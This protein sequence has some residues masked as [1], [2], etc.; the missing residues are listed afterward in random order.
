MNR[1]SLVVVIAISC[2]LTAA[3][4]DSKPLVIRG[5]ESVGAPVTPQVLDVN[6]AELPTIVPWRAGDPITEVPRR[7]YPPEGA[8]RGAVNPLPD[9]LA[10]LQASTP[11]QSMRGFT[12]PILA[13]E[14]V[15]FTGVHPPDPIGDIGPNHYIHALNDS[16][17]A[18]FAI[19]D[20]AGTLLAGPSKMDEIPDAG[21]AC[22]SGA[23]DPI[24]LYDRD[25][26]RWFMQEFTQANDL[27]IYISQGPDPVNDGWYLYRYRQSLFPDYP[28]FGVWP[29]GYYT[30]TN[31][32]SS[33]G[34]PIYVFDR[35]NMITGSTARPQQRFTIPK[36]SGYG[37]QAATPADLDGDALPPAGAGGI[38]MRHVDDEAHSGSPDPSGDTLDL[39]TVTIDWDN[40]GNSV[41]AAQT[42]I[43]ITEY[44]SWFEDYSTFYSVPQPDATTELDPIRECILQRLQYRRFD[45][46]ESLVGVFPT[47]IDPATTGDSVNAGLRWFELRRS[48]GSG[49]WSL[50]QEGTFDVGEVSENRFEGSVAM[51]QSGN[52]AM[53]YSMTRTADPVVYPSVRYTGRL[54]DDAASVMTQAEVEV[55]TGTD[56]QTS[57]GRWGDYASIN[58]DPTD[59]CT[60]WYSGMYMPGTRWATHVSSF[61]FE[62]CGCLLANVYEPTSVSA[63]VPGDNE[64]HLEWSDSATPEIVEYEVWR[65]YDAGGPYQQIE[66]LADTSLGT[67][68]TGT[69]QYDDTTVSG[70]STYYY[71]IRASDG[72]ACRS[73]FS[74]EVSATA[75]GLCTLDPT[76]AGIETASNAELQ[77]CTIDLTWSAGTSRC[78]G[79]LSYSV[80][81]STD[82]AF[83][84]DPSTR[85]AE[86]VGT[87]TYQDYDMLGSGTEYHYIVRATDSVNDAEETNTE[88]RSAAPSGPG[89][90]T[91]QTFD[92]TDTPISIDS[93]Q[94]Y[95]STINLSGLEPVADLEV[96]IDLTHTYIGDLIVELTSP[97]GTTVRLHNRS[98]GTA[99]DIITTYDSLTAPDG[100]G[101]MDDFNGETANGDW[102]LD[103]SDNAGGDVGALNSW[104][105]ILTPMVPCDT[106]AALSAAFTAPTHVCTGQVVAFT[107][108]STNAETWSWD[109][110]G[111]GTEDSD[112]Q[113]PTY[114]YATAGTYDVELTVTRSGGSQERAVVHTVTA[115]DSTSAVNGDADGSGVVDAADLAAWINELH[116]GDGSTAADRCDGFATTDQV[117]E[118]GSTTIESADL[119]SA[120]PLM[121]Q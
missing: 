30:T 77:D 101:V 110:D 53:A 37:F 60:F 61:K 99:E 39:Y 103:F 109:L 113:N 73:P 59:D 38:I 114:T 94:S 4:D 70:A 23:G 32:S 40:P 10:D 34:A 81:R 58:I 28:H 1:V 89:G 24:I 36:L 15:A 112:L 83:T 5:A 16:G 78:S 8:G 102:V 100:P 96:A 76:F 87:L 86:G 63:T 19:Y 111:D 13:F 50:H 41:V 26:D 48:G 21:D 72:S 43:D 68:S 115:I 71:V 108:G 92:S 11:L 85:I 64:I 80:Y 17:G 44:N 56:P 51:D 82:P 121:F 22:A 31:E 33:S 74:T 106:T 6:L 25:A 9:P 47:N 116:D 95:T 45:T 79:S 7:F 54:A 55:A 118:D 65:S 62:Q 104:S 90:G 29:D 67:G 97:A 105:L 52:M 93:N 14:A 107:D 88:V 75:T 66:T 3:A 2:A 27:C 18:L 91:P 20:K 46:H 49:D 98:G 84:P 42:P 12:D 35:A 119:A 57:S 117:D 69:Y 120:V